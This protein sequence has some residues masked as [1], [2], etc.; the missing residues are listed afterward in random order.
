M[1]SEHVKQLTT[2]GEGIEVEF[3][4]SKTKLN[5]SV[6]ET[7]CAFL[8]RN[9]GH[10]LLGVNDDGEI[11]GVDNPEKLINDFNTLANNFQKLDPTF[12]FSPE[13]IEIDGKQ[14]VYVFI[15]E[16]S[17]VHKA[18]GKIFDRNSDGDFDISNNTELVTALYI[19]KQTTYS[20]NTVFPYASVD[21]LRADLID[22]AKI[23]AKNEAG[24]SHPWTTLSN[25]AMLNSVGLYQKDL[26]TGQSGLTLAAILLFGKDETIIS[27]LPHHRTDAILRKINIDRYDDRDDIRTNLIE[28][29]DRLMAFVKKHLPDPF[30]LEDDKRISLRNKIFREAIS[31]ILIHREFINPFPAK[32]I[33]ESDKVLFENASRPHGFG[34]ITP[35]SFSPFPKNP[36]IARVFKEIG[37]A[38][39]LGSGVRNLFKYL[40][41]YSGIE[42]EII[43]GDI[44]KIVI[45]TTQVTTQV[46]TQATTQ[47]EESDERTGKI[48]E[49][50]KMPKTREEIQKFI[51]IKHREYFRKEIL[52]PLVEKG[53]LMLTIPDK[54][55]SPKQ[56]YYSATK[57][58]KS[59]Q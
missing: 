42:P 19:R 7:V 43:E 46:T 56:K 24:G 9:G 12:Y 3:K 29:Y 30:Y 58:G 2:Q 5:K 22:R 57:G 47:A 41:I 55:N 50:C 40:K 48:I 54:P 16:S 51:S 8:N 33:I 4:E 14:I 59:G 44:F 21:D 27:A 28:S 10:L 39:E 32:M 17:Q 13:I 18:N 11:A 45:T 1:T 15:P 35:E 52:K 37:L 25:R 38:D 53:L 6:F 20:E 49:F 34:L 31:N 23:M 26:R 36:N